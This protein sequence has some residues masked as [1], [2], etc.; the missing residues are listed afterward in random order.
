[1]NLAT[2]CNIV[3]EFADEHQ[4]GDLL[5][6]V[7]LM[8]IHKELGLLT[9]EQSQAITMFMTAGRKMFTTQGN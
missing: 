2:A 9:E 8:D 1:M 4:N 3:K 7:Q 5:E 6:G